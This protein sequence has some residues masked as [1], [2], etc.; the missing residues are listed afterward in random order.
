MDETEEEK[1]REQWF[2]HREEL[3]KNKENIP[4]DIDMPEE[5]SV[6][7]ELIPLKDLFIVLF[8]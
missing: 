6:G 5:Y 3:K 8:T 1:L 2:S 7:C 4:E